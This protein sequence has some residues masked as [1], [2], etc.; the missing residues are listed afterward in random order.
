ML[1]P[2]FFFFFPEDKKALH[3]F[4]SAKEEICS[5]TVWIITALITLSK[6]NMGNHDTLR[7]NP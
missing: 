7:K 6:Y 2:A 5:R 1:Y 3:Q 4:Y